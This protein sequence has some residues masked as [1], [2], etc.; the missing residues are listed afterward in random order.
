MKWLLV[1]H[2]SIEYVNLSLELFVEVDIF[3]HPQARLSTTSINNPLKFH[4]FRAGSKPFFMATVKTRPLRCFSRWMFP[5][6]VVPPNHPFLIGFSS[7]N[8]PF[9]GTH[10]FG[11]IQHPS[12]QEFPDHGN[13]FG[14]RGKW[15]SGASGFTVR[16]GSVDLDPMTPPV[17]GLQWTKGGAPEGWLSFRGFVGGWKTTCLGYLGMIINHHKDPLWNNQYFMESVSVSVFFFY[18]SVGWNRWLC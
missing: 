5:K 15:V 2:S 3:S 7:I 11:N 13:C 1:A 8:H 16:L 17:V 14:M 4:H 9:W 18:G 6:I 12:H 10:I